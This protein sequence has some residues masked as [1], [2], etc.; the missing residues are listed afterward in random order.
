MATVAEA[1]LMKSRRSIGSDDMRALRAEGS[2][3][4]KNLAPVQ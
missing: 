4:L 1:F 3:R 2:D